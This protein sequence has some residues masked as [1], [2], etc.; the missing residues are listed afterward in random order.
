[1]STWHQRK[2]GA[3]AGLWQPHPV[4]FKCV[5]DRPEQFA[6]SMLFDDLEQAKSYCERTGNVLVMPVAAKEQQP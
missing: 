4:H 5:S 6:S 2:G 3:L 1:M